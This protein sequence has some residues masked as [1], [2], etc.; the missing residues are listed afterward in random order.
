MCII[1]WKETKTHHIILG[2]RDEFLSRPTTKA[3]W[4]TQFSPSIPV[5][6]GLD[7]EAGGGW[8]GLSLVPSTITPHADED[9]QDPGGGPPASLRFA[10]LTN[11]TEPAHTTEAE[12]RPSRGHLIKNVLVHTE[13]T[14]DQRLP[15]LDETK[16][17]FAG[18]N[19][20]VAEWESRKG[21]W[22]MFYTSNRDAR[23]GR[24]I[25]GGRGTQ[26]DAVSNSTW[27]PTSRAEPRWPKVEAGCSLLDELISDDEEDEGIL[28]EKAWQL[29]STANP[30]PL[31]DR[32]HLRHTILVRPI[33]MNPLAPLPSTPTPFTPAPPDTQAPSPEVLPS[34]VE[35]PDKTE[36][37]NGYWYG[38]RVQSVLMVDKRD[39]K[40]RAVFVERDAYEIEKGSGKVRWSGEERRFELEDWGMGG[41]ILGQ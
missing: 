16:D 7:L 38:T 10:T 34:S 20:V 2:N 19:L 9:D 39:L 30:A 33:F 1:F 17:Q 36:G 12:K 13:S 24:R 4:H 40:G 27:E 31:L 11:F 21:V 5:L 14:I 15:T 26:A 3:A 41:R 35:D 6:S 28:L 37:R 23:P 29:L 18:F 8:W 32:T 22:S 25:T